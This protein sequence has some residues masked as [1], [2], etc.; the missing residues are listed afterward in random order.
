[1]VKSRGPYLDGVTFPVLSPMESFSLSR[2][3]FLEN[4]DSAVAD[5]D[6]NKSLGLYGFNFSFIKAFWDLLR[7]DMGTFF[8]KFYS[9]QSSQ[10]LFLLTLWK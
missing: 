6:G 5:C 9:I 4:I 3:F 10:V 7:L 8:E 2:P 1:M